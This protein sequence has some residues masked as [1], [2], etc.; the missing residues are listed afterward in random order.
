MNVSEG[1]LEMGGASADSKVQNIGHNVIRWL[2][3]TVGV[4]VLLYAMPLYQLF[5]FAAGS[6]LYSHILLIPFV[7]GY[8]IWLRRQ[9][10]EECAQSRILAIV[11]LGLGVALLAVTWLGIY[12]AENR[13]FEGNIAILMLSFLFLAYGAFIALMGWNN[14]R[15]F[16]FPAL[17]LLFL[18]PFPQWLLVWIETGLQHGSALVAHALFWIFGMPVLRDGTA[19]RLPAIR[20]QV[21]PECSGIHS[22][23]VLFITSLV[24]GQIFL[25]CN[26]HRTVLA[27][28]VI[29]L[30]LLRN[31]LR[32]FTIG[33]LCVHY[34]PKMF[35]SY[36]HR[37]GGPIFFAL[38]LIPLFLLL[39]WLWKMEAESLKRNGSACGIAADNRC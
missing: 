28:F 7:S 2:A 39:L 12:P 17:F 38:S 14:F 1:K 37:K 29:P 20:M 15:A 3:A 11:P 27:L 13:G 36:I 30:A 5:R 19:F 35:D 18:L 4:V 22:T 31:G 32:I 8:F 33:Q 25:K 9:R 23:L 10:C 16:L 34:G 6:D 21:A 24:A 26:C